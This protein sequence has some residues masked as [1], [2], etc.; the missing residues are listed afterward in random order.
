MAKIDH[1]Q[2][3]SDL[4]VITVTVEL[5]SEL[6]KIIKLKT[7]D[8]PSSKNILFVEFLYFFFKS[9]PEITKKYPPETIGMTINGGVPT[10]STVM[11]D[12]DILSLRVVEN[13]IN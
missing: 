10:T 9:Y 1:K 12:G 13:R 7:F 5:D 8:S 3:L 4:E 2:Q 6:Q 11:Q